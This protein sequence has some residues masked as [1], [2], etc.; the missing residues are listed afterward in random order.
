MKL[1]DWLS[2]QKIGPAEFGRR[3][4]YP[5]PT[6]HRYVNGERIPEPKAMEKIFAETGGAV[7][8]ND[9]YSITP[10]PEAAAP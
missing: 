1:A 5:Q 8:P 3:I 7:T 10:A 9:F 4:G 2:E 6:V